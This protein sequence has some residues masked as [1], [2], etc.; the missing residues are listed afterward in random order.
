MGRF[1]TCDRGCGE[2]KLELVPAVQYDTLAALA[3][4]ARVR[5]EAFGAVA[6]E[7]ALRQ[8]SAEEWEPAYRSVQDIARI[9]LRRY[10]EVDAQDV[11]WDEPVE[12]ATTWWCA[13]CGGID[14]P[15]PCLGICVWRAVEWVNGARYLEQRSGVLAERDTER[16]LRG[17]LRRVASVTPRAGEWERGWRALEAEAQRCFKPAR[18]ALRFSGP[19]RAGEFGC[20]ASES[21]NARALRWEET[22][23]D[24]EGAMPSD[25]PPAPGSRDSPLSQ[26]LGLDR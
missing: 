10:P 6:E 13:G 20:F 2:Q 14:A 19:P 18:T 12:F 22:H 11:D 7:L 15:Q 4:S 24:T 16:R 1:G 21:P 23:F 17:L 25:C 3:S 5:A 9:T 8:P 26:L